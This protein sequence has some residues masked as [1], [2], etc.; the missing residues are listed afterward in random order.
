MAKESNWLDE[1]PARVNEDGYLQL[2]PE[3]DEPTK[4]VVEVAQAFERAV[5]YEIA[6]GFP[7]VL[8]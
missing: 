1:I 7:G 5:E 2:I 6:N 4:S 8:N 3:N